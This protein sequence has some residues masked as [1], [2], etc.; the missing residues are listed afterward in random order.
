MF[1]G[2]VRE[3]IVIIVSSTELGWFSLRLLPLWDV[4]STGNLC[5]TK[6][7]GTGACILSSRCEC[8]HALP[9]VRLSVVCEPLFE[10]RLRVMY[11]MHICDVVY[12]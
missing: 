9:I 2:C 6:Y 5:C 10:G 8:C 12:V 4:M 3:S 1:G 11:V 7:V